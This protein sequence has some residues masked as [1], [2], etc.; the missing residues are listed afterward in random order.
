MKFI[1]RRFGAKTEGK[2]KKVLVAVAVAA[3][4]LAACSKPEDTVIPS[5][6]K[7]W[8]TQLA[9]EVK[10][11]NDGDKQ[12]LTGYLMR[13]KMG[14]AFGGA[15]MP[16]GTTVGQGIERQ[17]DWLAKQE[18]QK[19]EQERLKKEVEAQ[20]AAAAVELSKSVVL[21]FLSQR[22]VPKDIYAHRYS[23]EFLIDIAVQN[24]SQKPIKGIKADLVFKNTFGE[25]IYTSGLTIEQS[26][27]PAAKSTW[28]GG[29][30]LNEFKDSDKKLM[31]LQEGS[32]T[33]EIRPTMVVFADGSSIGSAE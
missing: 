14:E 18:A 6:P 22:I 27:Q 26:I 32:Y 20:R 10:K 9:P 3:F 16:V 28:E 33:A 24:A 11:L 19:A 15:P 8:D 31:N 4:T 30:E 21:A 5:D 25:T 12:L 29:H 23:D 2:M 1:N 13:I 7:N 17:K